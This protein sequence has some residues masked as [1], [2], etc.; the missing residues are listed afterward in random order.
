MVF[1]LTL[2]GPSAHRKE[3]FT[4]QASE[5]IT[6]LADQDADTTNSEARYLGY[7]ARLRTALRSAHR[8]VAYTSDVGEAFR[9]VV[10]PLVVRA[11]YG[12]SWAY[13]VG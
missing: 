13:L 2:P 12:V 10:S 6:A 4:M 9:P 3:P 8:Y 1:T 7:A 11:A 5:E